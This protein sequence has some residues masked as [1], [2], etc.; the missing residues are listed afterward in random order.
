VSVKLKWDFLYD[1]DKYPLTLTENF[2]NE[3]KQLEAAYLTIRSPSNWRKTFLL[4]SY[5]ACLNLLAGFLQ[6]FSTDYVT[7]RK[8]DYDTQHSKLLKWHI[9]KMAADVELYRQLSDTGNSIAENVD[10]LLE[11]I[12]VADDGDDDT[13]L[14]ELTILGAELRRSC[15]DV[16][17]QLAKFTDDLQHRLKFLE[18]RRNV[19]QTDSVERL[20]LLATLFLPMSLAAGLLSMQSRFKD[21][22]YLLYDFVGVVVLLGCLAMVALAFIIALSFAR[23]LDSRLMWYPLY[24][25]YIRWILAFWRVVSVALFTALLLASFLVGMFKNVVLGGRFL[26]YGTIVIASGPVLLISTFVV[27]VNVWIQMTR[28]RKQKRRAAETTDLEREPVQAE[29]G[30]DPGGSMGS[31]EN[32]NARGVTVN[33]VT[34]GQ[35]GTGGAAEQ[36]H[37]PHARTSNEGGPASGS[38]S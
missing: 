11:A 27:G 30:G 6:E 14:R 5:H 37:N 4:Q 15:R 19:T 20:T 9:E 7:A 1:P 18:L 34:D 2:V 32:K 24:R 33:F 29:R 26:G 3:L 23:E 36:V 10:S 8:R 21:L 25:G 12:R 35:Q 31:S 13:R 22:G 17:A 28:R 16:Q 38:P